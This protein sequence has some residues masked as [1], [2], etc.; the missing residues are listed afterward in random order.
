MNLMWRIEG[1]N[2]VELLKDRSNGNG[3]NDDSLVI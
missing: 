1:M 2:R 3:D